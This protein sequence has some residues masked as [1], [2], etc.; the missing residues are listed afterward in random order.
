MVVI[1]VRKL[2]P[3]LVIGHHQA[4]KFVKPC[5]QRFWVQRIS[6]KHT[7]SR[8]Y[9]PKEL[10]PHTDLEKV[11]KIDELS[12]KSTRLMKEYGYIKSVGY[13]YF[14]LLPL[15]TRSL[16]K[17]IK[18]IDNELETIGCQKLILPH[19]ATR[20][21]WEQS[22]RWQNMGPELVRFKDRHDKDML[23]CPTH[24]ETITSL[25]STYQLSYKDLPLRLYQVGT[26]FRGEMKPR[27]GLIRSNEFIMK[28]LYTFDSSTDAAQQT[29][30]EVSDAYG[31]IFDRIGVPYQRVEGDTGVIGGSTSHEFHYPADI[32]Q[33]S[34]LWCK[35]C[36]SG[37]NLELSNNDGQKCQMCGK[38]MIQTKGIEVGHTFLL[39]QKYSKVFKAKCLGVNG[40]P[41]LMEMG[42]YGIGVTRVLAAT[43]EVLSTET[44]L[45]WPNVLAPFSICILPPKSGSKEFAAGSAIVSELYENLKKSFPQDIIIDD[46]ESMT[47]G[48]KLYES[49]RTGYPIIIVIGKKCSLPEPVIEVQIPSE[50]QKLEL[51][52]VEAVQYLESVSYKYSLLS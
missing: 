2:L 26:K 17:L 21:L 19:T 27:F 42:C 8:L 43:V 18:L 41:E 47:I 6:L 48:K 12:S 34:L 4:N 52:P 37:T 24:E 3:D 35:S 51:S 14:A 22:G 31:K 11:K 45:R 7:V 49:N 9:Q 23:L 36:N 20:K 5:L 29:Y 16:N 33:D 50:N 46:R 15:A 44:E 25:V 38:D 28:D 13:G 39:G 32:G 1:G 30:T 10:I 40:K